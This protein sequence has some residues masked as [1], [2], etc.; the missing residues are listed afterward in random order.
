MAAITLHGF[1][2][3]SYVRTARMACVEKGVDY[4][5]DP[6]RP[7]ETRERG[8]HP[9]GK[10]PAMTNGAIKLFETSAI[11]R[12]VDEHFDGPALQPDNPE[13][14]ATMNQWISAINDVVFDAM[15]RRCFIRY[16]FLLGA[17][18]KPDRSIIDPALEQAREQFAALDAAYGDNDYLAGG[19]LSLADLFLAPIMAVMQQVPEGPALFEASPNLSRAFTGLSARRSFLE[20]DPADA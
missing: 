14:R 9:F 2:A 16:F 3:S 19:R 13:A 4:T 1:P 6:L 18:G 5:L 12:Y 20:T 8:L 17:D 11:T 10:V 15:V 7:G